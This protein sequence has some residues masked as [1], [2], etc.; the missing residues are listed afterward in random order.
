MK[1]VSEMDFRYSE[2]NKVRKLADSDFS[3]LSKNLG[4][5]IGISEET[6]KEQIKKFGT[7]EPIVKKF[8]YFKKFFE[9]LIEPFNLLL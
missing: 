9:V 7:N 2:T 4:S 1:K 8:N 5:K 3:S 6:R